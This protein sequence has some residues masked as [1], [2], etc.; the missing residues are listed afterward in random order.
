MRLDGTADDPFGTLHWVTGSLERPLP[1]GGRLRLARL[2]PPPPEGADLGRVTVVTG[3]LLVK[4]GD[5]TLPRAETI[6]GFGLH[7]AHPR[8][9]PA[10]LQLESRLVR[11]GQGWTEPLLPDRALVPVA[12]ALLHGGRDR[13]AEIDADSLFDVDGAD[14]DPLDER[15]D[16]RG[17]DL[18]GRI[19]ELG[20][21]CVPDL[22]WEWRASPPSPPDTPN[23]PSK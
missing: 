5:P 9:P 22:T 2:D 23:P 20:L 12:A 7:P 16:H 18:V 4:D 1:R 15:D 21:L 13:F 11:D 6:A 8:Y 10:V 19:D 14:G 17:V 3:T